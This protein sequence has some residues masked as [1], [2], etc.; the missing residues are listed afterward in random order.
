MFQL[1][2]VM[3]LCLQLI[4]CGDIK[5]KESFSYCSMPCSTTTTLALD[6]QSRVVDNDPDRLLKINSSN[7]KLS[8]SDFRL[9]IADLVLG[10]AFYVMNKFNRLF[11]KAKS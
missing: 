11:S 2:V 6:V 10:H 4:Q 1:V 5:R 7:K 8:V 3:L 9:P